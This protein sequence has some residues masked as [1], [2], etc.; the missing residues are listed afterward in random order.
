MTSTLNILFRG[1]A[2]RIGRGLLLPIALLV[3]V[4]PQA[5]GG[6]APATEQPTPVP[7]VADD[8][9][10][11]RRLTPLIDR[12]ARKYGLE[13]ALVH[14]VITVESDYDTRAVSEAGALGLMQVLPETARDYGVEDAEA[15][16]D[17]EI[18]LTT[19]TRHL[20]RLIRRYR[21]ISHALMAYNAGEGEFSD[22]R[23]SG[24]F[25]ETRRYMIRIVETY[26]RIKGGLRSSP[27]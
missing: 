25:P 16:F 14:A 18:N 12:I 27:P 17:P 5:E 2:I 21:N 3:T 26:R 1:C 22:F 7:G 11:K 6:D 23:V 20:R 13:P 10:D 24:I 15:L 8:A 4:P 9:R 19:G